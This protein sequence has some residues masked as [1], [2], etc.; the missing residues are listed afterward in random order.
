VRGDG[1]PE[2]RPV[3]RSARTTQ[4]P[5]TQGAA[6]SR[7]APAGLGPRS[8]GRKDRARSVRR[9]SELCPRERSQSP[10]AH[11]VL[12]CP[13][14]PACCCVGRAPVGPRTAP[15]EA[16]RMR[17]KREARAPGGRGRGRAATGGPPMQEAARLGTPAFQSSGTVLLRSG[18][19]A[20]PAALT[21][22]PQLARRCPA[23]R[24][25]AHGTAVCRVRMRWTGAPR[26]AA[27]VGRLW[28]ESPSRALL[29]P[30][31]HS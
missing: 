30:S 15:R 4:R 31:R 18:L 12:R 13:V 21:T 14:A 25:P 24:A 27:F 3:A 6:R 29:Q 1:G 17:C 5:L 23:P 7:R 16:L 8:G 28:R 9:A 11:A 19:F 20:R 2:R 22:R 10:S 26:C